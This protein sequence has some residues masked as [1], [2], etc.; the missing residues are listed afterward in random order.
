MNP[1]PQRYERI[2]LHT[3]STWSDGA[4]T[5]AELVALVATRQVQLLALTTTTPWPAAPRPPPPAPPPDRFCPGLRADRAVARSGDSNIVGLGLDTTSPATGR[6]SGRRAGPTAGGASRPIGTKLTKMR[7]GCGGMLSRPCG[8]G[9]ERRREHMAQPPGGATVM[10]PTWTDRLQGL[11]GARAARRGE[12]RQLA[13]LKVTVAIIV[14]PPAVSRCWPTPTA[15][16]PR[17][18]PA[19]ALLRRSFRDAGWKRRT[20]K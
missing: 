14:R 12:S 16:G 4:L 7:P 6:S 5:P 9:R 11:A 20:S 10:P 8:R 19:G 3:H 15:T 1:G 2:D 18:R 13:S 17:R